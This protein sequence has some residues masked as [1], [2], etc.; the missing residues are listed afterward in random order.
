MKNHHRAEYLDTGHGSAYS[1]LGQL[2]RD[3]RSSQLLGEFTPRSNQGAGQPRL[4]S[5]EA[6][7]PGSPSRRG[8]SPQIEEDIEPPRRRLHLGIVFKVVTIGFSGGQRA[9]KVVSLP[10]GKQTVRV[11]G[12]SEGVVG[13]A[14]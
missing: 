2:L 1:P 12:M 13:M 3:V 5:A 10:P 8:L 6:G 11:K 7:L 14:L 9:D 4:G